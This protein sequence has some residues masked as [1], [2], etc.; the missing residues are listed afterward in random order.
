MIVWGSITLEAFM[1]S[2]VGCREQ[3]YFPK[4]S[5]NVHSIPSHIHVSTFIGP[6]V[7]HESIQ[8]N[9]AQ[10]ASAP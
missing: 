5:S 2:D 10:K 1:E 6:S 9:R 8:S 3:K 7:D 4:K